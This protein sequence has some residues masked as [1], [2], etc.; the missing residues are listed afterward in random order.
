MSRLLPLALLPLVACSSETSFLYQSTVDTFVQTPNDEV[1]ILFVVDDSNSMAEEQAALADAF[2]DF[3]AEIENANS[4]FQIG[5]VTTSADTDDPRVGELIGSPPFLTADDDY[6]SKF[7]SRVQ[8]G[9]EGSDKEK[10]LAAAAAALSPERLAGTNAGFIRPDANLLVAVV[11][12]E[13]DCSD[14]GVLDG[15]DSDACYTNPEFLAPV[16]EYL[17]AI[18]DAKNGRADLVS[19]GAIISPAS[20][21][22]CDTAYPAVRYALGAH[23]LGGMVG[24]I[25]QPDWSDMLYD[26]G[27]TAS[28]LLDEF[29]LSQPA[30]EESIEVTVNGEPVEQSTRD[31]WSYV[32]SRTA[33]L[34][35]GN[36]IPPRG[37][38]VVV[39]YEI[40]PN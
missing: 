16:G 6:V 32:P 34:F 18:V 25:C 3:I 27:L 7:K 30:L 19:F 4:K 10:G 13:E 1:D 8:V 24:N 39:Q 17:D 31:G 22:A 37:A 5:V 28:G 14:D 2:T 40:Q 33:V 21:S 12:D 29:V 35:L 36:A 23:E 9:V 20:D 15:Y 26:L 38:E 11:S